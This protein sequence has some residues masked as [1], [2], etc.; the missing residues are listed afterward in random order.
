MGMVQLVVS[1]LV[2]NARKYA[3]GPCLL[4]L[5]TIE[6]AP[7][8]SPRGT[9]APPCHRSRHRTRT[10]SAGTTWRSSWRSPSYPRRPRRERPCPSGPVR[11][12]GGYQWQQET[13]SLRLSATTTEAPRPASWTSLDETGTSSTPSQVPEERTKQRVAERLTTALWPGPAW[14]RRRARTSMPWWVIGDASAGPGAGHG[15]ADTQPSTSKELTTPACFPKRAPFARAR[16]CFDQS[17]HPLAHTVIASS[18]LASAPD[19][20]FGRTFRTGPMRN[21]QR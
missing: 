14:V 19:P 2:S 11:S 10:A 4:D 1:E 17:L 18:D 12:G 20:R 13:G 16:L 5:E 9:T 7:S 8:R 21:G 3:P 15:R 6:G